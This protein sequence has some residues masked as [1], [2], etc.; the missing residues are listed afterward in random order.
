MDLRPERP[1]I[2]PIGLTLDQFPPGV[3]HGPPRMGNWERN[4]VCLV[5]SPAACHRDRGRVTLARRRAVIWGRGR[6]RDRGPGHQ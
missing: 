4:S 5:T 1:E 6:R 2:A 3:R